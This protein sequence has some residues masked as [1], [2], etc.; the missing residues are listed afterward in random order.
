[1]IGN[2]N[3]ML[4]PSDKHGFHHHCWCPSFG[5]DFCSKSAL[6]VMHVHILAIHTVAM[7]DTARNCSPSLGMPHAKAVAQRQCLRSN[8]LLPIEPAHNFINCAK[9]SSPNLFFQLISRIKV[10][11]IPK[12][13]CTC[14]SQ[15]PA[16]VALLECYP[17][18]RIRLLL[19]A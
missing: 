6:H 5:N 2:V 15:W 8:V 3:L 14:C 7:H 10:L 12:A 4:D 1:M 13:A 9:A 18:T 17:P 19:H 11:C 16:E